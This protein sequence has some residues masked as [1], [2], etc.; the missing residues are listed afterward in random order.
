VFSTHV[1]GMVLVATDRDA[2][3]TGPDG[4][5]IALRQFSA[6]PASARMARRWAAGVARDWGMAEVETLALLTSELA[7]NAV[8]HAQSDFEVKL[9]M[10]V[11][12]VRVEVA[13]SDPRLPIVLTMSVDGTAGRGLGVVQALASA[14]GFD[15]RV[16][17]KSVWFELPALRR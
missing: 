1:T 17:G 6:E 11:E 9:T 5:E 16:P 12:L 8:V 2:I 10:G 4:V 3:T 13:D 15:E 14:W 7:T